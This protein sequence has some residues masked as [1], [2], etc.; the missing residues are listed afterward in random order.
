MDYKK[1]QYIIRSLDEIKV[2]AA[3]MYQIDNADEFS[4]Q[5]LQLAMR[6]EKL[7]DKTRNA[8]VINT[9]IDK[10][11]YLSAASEELGITVE[12]VG[13]E[14]RITLPYLLPKKKTLY[15]DRYIV[16]PLAYVLQKYVDKYAPQKIRKALVCIR[17]VYDE[18]S[19]PKHIRDTDNT[20]IS[21]V[22]NIISTMLLVDDNMVDILLC[23]RQ[24]TYTHT[25]ITVSERLDCE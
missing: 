4:E 19:N 7:T 9:G 20:E 24:G 13:E 25:E 18:S 8:A 22:M 1:L 17:S 11:V 15:S 6:M 3:S 21:H 23:S 5:F 16:E 2:L 10:D 12:K 14:V